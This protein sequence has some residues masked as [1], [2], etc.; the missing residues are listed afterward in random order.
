MVKRLSKS[1]LEKSM[2][3]WV[4]DDIRY[5]QVAIFVAAGGGFIGR[6][7]A[8]KPAVAY[9]DTR[10]GRLPYSRTEIE[11]MRMTLVAM[12]EAKGLDPRH[13]P[14]RPDFHSCGVL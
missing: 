11:N 5:L 12:A 7:F 8:E 14:K 10:V 1:E 2:Q 3:Y 4:K 9:I 6:M 13:L